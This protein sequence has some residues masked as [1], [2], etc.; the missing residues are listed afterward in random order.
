[1]TIKLQ[2]FSLFYTCKISFFCTMLNKDSTA[3]LIPCVCVCVLLISVFC[4]LSKN[5][6]LYKVEHKARDIYDGKGER[7]TIVDD[8]IP[9]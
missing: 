2:E 6:F 8:F 1:M 4:N 7:F 3:W 5:I 9:E